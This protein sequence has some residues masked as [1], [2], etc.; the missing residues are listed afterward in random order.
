VQQVLK[1]ATTLGYMRTAFTSYVFNKCSSLLTLLGLRN[2]G[3]R[4]LSA[5]HRQDQRHP[6]AQNLVASGT[7]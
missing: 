6:P 2:R 7:C 4:E 1:E 5:A 3:V